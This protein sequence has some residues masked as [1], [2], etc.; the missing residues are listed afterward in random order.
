MWR[1]PKL[2]KEWAGRAPWKRL[3]R[4]LFVIECV[5]ENYVD[6][7][8]VA[9]EMIY[10]SIHDEGLVKLLCE[11]DDSERDE[12]FFEEFEVIRASLGQMIECRGV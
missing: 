3:L 12:V 1:D 4:G 7:W 2:I 9:S 8:E 11:V 6:M 10:L 5:E